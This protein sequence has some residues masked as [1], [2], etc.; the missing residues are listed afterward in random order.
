[1]GKLFKLGVIVSTAITGSFVFMI[2]AF[3]L[4][5]SFPLFDGKLFFDFFTL[6]WDE[7]TG[8][9]GLLPM[10]LGTVYISLLATFFATLM[11]FSL[12][13]LIDSFL[14]KK[15]SFFLEG[16]FVL[17]CGVPTV[18]Y[19]F[20][21]LFLVVPFINQYI[22]Q[23][24]GLSILSA[25]FVLS[26]VVLPTMS[27]MF[28]NAF[29]SMPKKYKTAGLSLGL[30]SQELFFH[31]IL[32]YAKRGIAS[33]VI[34]GFSRAVGDTLIALMLAGNTLA[35]PHSLLDSAR[36][37]TAHIALI[38]ANDYESVAFKAIFLS[39]LLL[40]ILTCTIVF[41]VRFIQKRDSYD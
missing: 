3:L 15:V 37:L 16:L 29:R 34:F 9:Y 30:S 24:K 10:V 6:T 27:I 1:M 13:S 40:F 2:L 18:V 19:A 14:P 26:F 7:K 38:N 36:T 25:S 11:A 31:M 23:S 32:P 41:S 22:A 20:G 5:F 33:A 35:I 28:L 17:L 21:A 8:H 12:A 39:A 4:Y